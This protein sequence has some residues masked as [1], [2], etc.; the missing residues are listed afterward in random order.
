MKDQYYVWL[1]SGDP[2]N[3]VHPDRETVARHADYLRSLPG[4]VLCAGGEFKG[5]FKGMLLLNVSS[6]EEAEAIASKD[7][8]I[9]GGY[10]NYEIYEWQILIDHFDLS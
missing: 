9:A 7:P 3:P 5:C 6:R 2:A 10:M 1:N 8:L 4:E